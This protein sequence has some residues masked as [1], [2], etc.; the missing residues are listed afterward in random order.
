MLGDHADFP[1]YLLHL[2]AR[3]TGDLPSIDED[4]ALS[5]PDRQ[6]GAP[7]QSGLAGATGTKNHQAFALR[8]LKVNVFQGEFGLACGRVGT[9]AATLGP[10]LIVMAQ[11]LD[12]DHLTA[13][14]KLQIQ[15][16]PGIPDYIVIGVRY[17]HIFLDVTPA[18]DQ[19]YG[20]L[21][22]FDQ[23]PLDPFLQVLR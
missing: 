2:S 13:F 17:N 4:P 12:S 11:T 9:V 20:L 15:Q 23:S 19:V 8:N 16:F 5:G 14:Q 18:R 3:E 6:V 22:H 21:V 10:D 1:T 7:E